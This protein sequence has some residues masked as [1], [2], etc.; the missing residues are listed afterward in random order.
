M[1]EQQPSL[2]RQWQK[3]L[4]ASFPVGMVLTWDVPETDRRYTA[5]YFI[6]RIEVTGQGGLD[7][8]VALPVFNQ[9]KLFTVRVLTY[10][11]T[12]ENPLVAHVTAESKPSAMW[13]SAGVSDWAAGQMA[14][15]RKELT[16]YT[17]EYGQSIYA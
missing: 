12:H 1:T 5:R 14:A 13:W 10:E 6:T 3:K 16:D 11:E 7:P 4:D 8:V 9:D 2:V 17:E 15:L